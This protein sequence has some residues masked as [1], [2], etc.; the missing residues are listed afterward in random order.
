[1]SNAGLPLRA[2]C[3]SDK[4]FIS[5]FRRELEITSRLR[6]PSTIRV[7]EHGE[8]EDGRPYMVMELLTGES[9]ADR[10]EKGRIDEIEALQTARQ[11]AE[12]LSE[13]HENGIFH[14]DL[15]GGNILVRDRSPDSPGNGAL[16]F[17][18]IDTSRMRFYRRL[19]TLPRLQDLARIRLAPRDRRP[20]LLA[21]CLG[22]EKVTARLWP[23]Y[24]L[25]SLL[26]RS[27]LAMKRW[28]RPWKWRHAT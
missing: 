18:I 16:E 10:M 21:Y 17:A 15:T 25:V 24:R 19:G 14:R 4:K 28:L 6:H 26:Y 9:L 23:R 13:A 22:D 27:K 8:A 11:V 2:E 7:F 3:A 12:S 5:R 20:F 1:M